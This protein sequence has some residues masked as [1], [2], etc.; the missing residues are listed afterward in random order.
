MILYLLYVALIDNPKIHVGRLQKEIA[1]HT[2]WGDN[3]KKQQT[4]DETVTLVIMECEK[5][6]LLPCV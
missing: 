5:S 1:W 4:I 2:T 6:L 3:V